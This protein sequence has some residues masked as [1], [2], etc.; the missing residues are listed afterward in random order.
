M[1]H[2]ISIQTP[3]DIKAFEGS[4]LLPPF[5]P[6]DLARHAPDA[7]WVLIADDNQIVG[8]CSLWWNTTPPY[9]E[10]RVGLIGH[11]AA[12]DTAAARRLLQNACEQLADHGCTMAIGPMDGSTWRRYRLMTERGTEPIFFLEPDNPDDWPGHFVDQGFTALAHYSSALTTDLAQQDPR[13]KSV[14]DRLSVM[15]VHIRPLDVQQFEQELER[16]YEVSVTSF[17]N[18]FLYTPIGQDEFVEMYR[19]VRPFL[20]P[21]C[22]LMAEHEG[23]PVGFL[24]AVPDW[25]QAQRGLAIDT[26]IIKTVAVL[27]DRSHAGLGS[28]LV[29]RGHRI[30]CELGYTR[31][32]HALMHDSNNSR[33]IS[34]R[35]AQPMRGYTLFAKSLV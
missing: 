20:R 23:R 6:E 2:L 7:H 16:I 11:Y 5:D 14:A 31:A 33:N 9:A 30:A 27:P 8:R 19:R 29:E 22:V 28:F 24:F 34:R 18:N 35:S 10:H 21:E 25:L 17:R 3:E 12:R 26:I 4:A 32:I 15:G 1:E 13:M